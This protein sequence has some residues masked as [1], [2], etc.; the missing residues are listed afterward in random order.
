MV[1]RSHWYTK[2]EKDNLDEREEKMASSDLDIGI[3]E[4]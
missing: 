4:D 1:D 3:I 2:E